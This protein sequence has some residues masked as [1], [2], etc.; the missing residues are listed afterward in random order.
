MWEEGLQEKPTARLGKTERELERTSA[1][2]GSLSAWAN[3]GRAWRLATEAK[4]S[5]W[6]RV[7]SLLESADGYLF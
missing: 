5:L 3:S 7:K 6:T 1:T 2:A 4:R